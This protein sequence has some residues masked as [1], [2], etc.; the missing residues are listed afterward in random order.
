[1]VRNPMEV[2]PL[3]PQG[4]SDRWMWAIVLAATALVVGLAILKGDPGRGSTE[5]AGEG[6][7]APRVSLPLLDGKGNASLAA[8]RVTV[9]DFWATWCAPCR[10]SM[11]RVQ[12]LWQEYLPKGV[13]LYSVD[14]DN[15]SNDREA[16]VKEFLLQYGLTF[17]VVLDDGSAQNAFAIAN[18]PTIVVVDQKGR[19]VWSHIGA[20]TAPYET[21]LRGILDR[22]L[23]KG[24][25]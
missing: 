7:A 11:P 12:Q 14:T 6:R 3:A 10:A 16:L 21:D 2:R 5:K 24:G 22:T 18:L 9:V 19:I 17:P 4:T 15:A 20:L 8:G 13:D 25:L 23:A 1:M